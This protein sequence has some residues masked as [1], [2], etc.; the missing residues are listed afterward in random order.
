MQYTLTPAFRRWLKYFHPQVYD[1]VRGIETC[2]VDGDGHRRKLVFD[3]LPHDT[4]GFDRQVE[5]SG[6][7]TLVVDAP[8]D[9]LET[10][11]RPLAPEADVTQTDVTAVAEDTA[12]FDLYID[13]RLLQARGVETGTLRM[14][15]RHKVQR[16]HREAFMATFL[17][18][19]KLSCTLDIDE[20]AISKML[21]WKE[22]RTEAEQQRPPEY[23][24]PFETGAE[25]A[26]TGMMGCIGSLHTKVN[27]L[28][29]LMTHVQVPEVVLH[30]LGEVFRAADRRFAIDQASIQQAIWK[31][32]RSMPPEHV[33]R[34]RQLLGQEPAEVPFTCKGDYLQGSWSALQDE[35]QA[36]ANFSALMTG[37]GGR[38]VPERTG[39]DAPGNGANGANGANE[40]DQ[41]EKTPDTAG[42]GGPS[43][44]GPGGVIP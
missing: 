32:D 12:D 2:E 13:C 24:E 16:V 8:L 14:A 42:G 33:A 30:H 25:G 11:D 37:G 44:S 20:I 7:A 18:T 41:A 10:S 34:I 21:V 23:D 28:Y 22:P 4:P 19:D 27:A 43:D 35:I 29:T 9:L 5:D 3:S 38:A 6:G 36:Q 26:I 15:R 17:L 1:A 39:E 40:T 31:A